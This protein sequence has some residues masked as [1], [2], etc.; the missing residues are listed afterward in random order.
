MKHVNLSLFI[1]GAAVAASADSDKEEVA[2]IL[3]RARQHIRFD[4]AWTI[5][6]G[7]C[8]EITDSQGRTV[9]SLAVTTEAADLAKAAAAYRSAVN[10]YLGGASR[11]GG[12]LPKSTDARTIALAKAS[13][14]LS[15][16]LYGVQVDEDL[17]GAHTVSC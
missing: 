12:S 10:A 4:D 5:E 13:K 6:P 3:E 1:A 7:F 15:S 2:S 11:H 17:P 14:S 9:G 8:H 16:L